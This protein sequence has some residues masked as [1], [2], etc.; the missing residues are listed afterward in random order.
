M[1]DRVRMVS[2]VG[3]GVARVAKARVEA[4]AANGWREV[5]GPKPARATKKS[6]GA[7]KPAAAKKDS[8][9]AQPAAD[10]K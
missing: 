1:S 10:A 8:G 4:F 2:P 9:E 7:A 3:R 5:A 6:G